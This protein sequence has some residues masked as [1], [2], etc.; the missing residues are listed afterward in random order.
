MLVDCLR[1]Q[2]FMAAHSPST[3]PRSFPAISVREASTKDSEQHNLCAAISS[4]IL[5]RAGEHNGYAIRPHASIATKICAARTPGLSARDAWERFDA[6]A[7]LAQAP[8]GASLLSGGPA[9][10]GTL[11][12]GASGEADGEVKAGGESAGE[13][14]S[15]PMDGADG[16]EGE[17]ADGADHGD[18]VAE[19][20]AQGDESGPQDPMAVVDG[21]MNG[22]G[23]SA[24]LSTAMCDQK[25]D[26]AEAVGDNGACDNGNGD[27]VSGDAAGADA[28]DDTYVPPTR[29]DGVITFQTRIL[30]QHLVC[31]LV[32]ANAATR[33]PKPKRLP[34]PLA[35]LPRDGR[36][37]PSHPRPRRSCRPLSLPTCVWR[38]QLWLGLLSCNCS[39]H[40]LTV[41]VV[42]LLIAVHGVLQRCLHDHRMLTHVLSRVHHAP[43]S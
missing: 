37:S 17:G 12:G 27:A 35:S 4:E 5:R 20:D 2:E 6:E 23:D 16:G 34:H 25:Q 42:P 8:T 24:V 39:V 22:A 33:L 18:A 26:A 15:D 14:A 13:A 21:A 30:N 10:S 43:L 32:R 40:A 41:T 1:S 7:F 19:A 28:Y 31:T 36:V 11:E 29:S 38:L 9:A 3:E